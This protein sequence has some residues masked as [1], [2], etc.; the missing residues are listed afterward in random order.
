MRRDMV[1]KFLHSR[2]TG[3]YFA[4]ARE[5]EVGAGDPVHFLG[6][7][8]NQVSVDDITRLYA[9]DKNDLAGMRRAIEVP[10]LPDGWRSYFC[11]RLRSRRDENSRMCYNGR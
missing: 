1:K 5:G 8:E 9:F 7:E 2:R 3:F 4:V 11:E 10:A 6:R